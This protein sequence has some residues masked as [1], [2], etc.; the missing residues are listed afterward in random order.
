[1]SDRGVLPGPLTW[2]L[3]RRLLTDRRSQLLGSSAKAALL[4]LTLGV[5]ALALSLA[6]LT[7]Y[8][9]DLARK[10]I[11]GNA[12]ILVALP[13]EEASAPFDAVSGA[14]AEPIAAAAAEAAI[15]EIPGVTRVDR[16]LYLEGV[17]D[18]GHGEAEVTL[19]AA[20]RGAGPMSAAADE[21]ARRDDGAWGVLLGAR[22]A[23]RLGLVEGDRARLTVVT[24]GGARPRFAFRALEV[25]GVFASGFSE[26]DRAW[27][28]VDPA[29]IA[30]LPGAGRGVI[31]VAV[32][33][34]S[35]APAIADRIREVVGPE[36]LVADWRQLNR[37]LFAAL[38]LQRRA[39]FLLLGLIVVVATFNVASTLVV[40]VRERMRD[41]GVL[42]S[43]G[44]A[45][46]GLRRVFLA[47]GAALGLVGTGLGLGLAA[48]ISWVVTR[49]EL[50]S[51]GP[52]IAEV[53]FL[54]SV[55]LRLA[56]GDAALIAGFALA[57]TLAACFVPAARAARLDPAAALRYE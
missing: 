10:L 50:L 43:I 31:E 6:L 9:E 14:P 29:A 7:G 49:F 35:A 34:P 42:A 22:R 55:P 32:E 21:L 18:G 56:P 48:A 46:A 28:V 20:P 26:F 17:L 27:A 25:A 38:D 57:V 33:D 47:Y 4:A 5:T 36:A 8:Q 3:A 16:V 41:L 52:E 40:L 39:L 2:T 19:R 53:Y 11:G 24:L 23:E 37:G 44:L 51:F 30:E 54:E 15:R 45:P 12:A 13:P 1:M